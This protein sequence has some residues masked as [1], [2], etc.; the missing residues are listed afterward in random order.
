MEQTMGNE[1]HKPQSGDRNLDYVAR[2]D[3]KV[4]KKRDKEIAEGEKKTDEAVK[5]DE[6]IR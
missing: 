1:S 6:G 5:R 2:E 4:Q 3:A